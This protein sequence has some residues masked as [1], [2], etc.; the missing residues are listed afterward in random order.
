MNR[1]FLGIALLLASTIDMHAQ[2]PSDAWRTIETRHFRVHYPAEYEAWATRAAER[3]EPIHSAVSKEVG[4]TPAQRID[5]LVMNP[6]AEPN[7]S[8]WPFLDTP[9]IIFYTEPPGP[10]DQIGA[11]T[12]WIDLL[13]VHEVAHIVHLMR[14]SRNPMRRLIEQF[15]VP[16]NR[17]LWDAPRWVVEG[18]AT[19]IEGRLTG[20][21][22]PSCRD[23]V[24]ATSSSR[25]RLRRCWCN[26]WIRRP[27]LPSTMLALLREE[28][29]S[30]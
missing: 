15:V 3:L 8:A 20:A 2:V 24:R 18:Y 27:T 9:R 1:L 10:D 30:P 16:L 6:V 5:V 13:A 19:V 12:N 26:S 21:G 11:Y 29:A 23:I 4:F 14:P 25:I 28:R 17:I 22:R 7:G